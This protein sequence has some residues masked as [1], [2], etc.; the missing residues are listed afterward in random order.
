MYSEYII[1]IEVLC[2]KASLTKEQREAVMEFAIAACDDPHVQHEGKQLHLAFKEFKRKGLF[3]DFKK[4]IRTPK[5]WNT[6]FDGEN[7]IPN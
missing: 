4:C 5:S 7:G 6:D 1:D 3:E 2:N